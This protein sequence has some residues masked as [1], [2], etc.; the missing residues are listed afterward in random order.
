MTHPSARDASV[1]PCPPLPYEPSTLGDALASAPPAE[2]RRLAHDVRFTA[3]VLWALVAVT[4]LSC[5][6]L[7]GR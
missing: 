1:P 5:A 7:A 3:A 4:A 6:I 2:R